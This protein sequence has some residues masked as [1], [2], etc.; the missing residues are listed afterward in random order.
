[1]KVS[2]VVSFRACLNLITE[3]HTLID[4]EKDLIESLRLLIG[5]GVTLLPVQ[6][7]QDQKT[8]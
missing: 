2:D 7:I 5:F 8:F 6:G 4:E 3:S 1:M